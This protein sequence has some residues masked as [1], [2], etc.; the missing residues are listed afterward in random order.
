MFFHCFRYVVD[1]FQN[2]MPCGIAHCFTF[3][4]WI[5]HKDYVLASVFNKALFYMKNP[6]IEKKDGTII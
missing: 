3:G 2:I 6:P 4:C 1:R 5:E